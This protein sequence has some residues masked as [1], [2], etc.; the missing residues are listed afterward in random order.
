VERGTGRC[1]ITQNI[2]GLH[3]KSGIS[4]DRVIELHGNTTFAACLQCAKRFEL[5]P[6]RAAFE[7]DESFP[8]LALRNYMNGL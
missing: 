7:R 8:V 6:I 5:E 1:V 4:G 2:N 3:Q